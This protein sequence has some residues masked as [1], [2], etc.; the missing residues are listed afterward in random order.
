[1]SEEW[2]AGLHPEGTA[3]WRKLLR[4][5]AA[6]DGS[7]HGSLAQAQYGDAAREAYL[8]PEKFR[9]GAE[10]E[11][12]AAAEAASAVAKPT[13]APAGTKPAAPTHRGR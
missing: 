9:A 10:A 4:L 5:R 12:E 1:M 3:G 11:E 2:I 6:A 7:A 8:D 13:P